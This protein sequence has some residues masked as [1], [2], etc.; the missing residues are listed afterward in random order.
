MCHNTYQHPYIAGGDTMT[1]ESPHEETCI[2]F[3]AGK[4]Y[5]FM[6]VYEI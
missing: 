4:L 3:S 2:H 5:A 6:S 1:M